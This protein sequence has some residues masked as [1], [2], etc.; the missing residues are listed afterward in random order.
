MGNWA[1]RSAAEIAAAVREKRVAPREVVAEHLA[2]ID[3]HDG[4]IGAFH[5]V[6]GAAALAE[7]DEVASR[8]D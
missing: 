4:R 8:A 3:R 6:R 7:A 1:G 5:T 2:R